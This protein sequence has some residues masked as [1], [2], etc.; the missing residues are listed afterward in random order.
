MRR[1]AGIL[2]ILIGIGLILLSI[3]F[4]TGSSSRM[5]LLGNISK[6]ELELYEG[7]YVLDAGKTGTTGFSGLDLIPTGH[8]EGRVAIPLKYPLAFSVVLILLGTGILLMSKEN[9]GKKR[10]PT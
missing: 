1:N 9:N 5:N 3:L 8:Y 10:D 4:S 2:A 7:N 6:M